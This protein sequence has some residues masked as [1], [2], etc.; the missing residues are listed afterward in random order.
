MYYNVPMSN[1]FWDIEPG[2]NL[3][4]L[5]S[6]YPR[7]RYKIIQALEDSETFGEWEQEGFSVLLYG[8]HEGILVYIIDDPALNII[9]DEFLGSYQNEKN[10]SNLGLDT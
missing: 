7:Q 6:Q 8:P 9:V 5:S 1:S 3:D 4:S 10:W 2:S